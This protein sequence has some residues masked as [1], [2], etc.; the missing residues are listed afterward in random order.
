MAKPTNTTGDRDYGRRTYASKKKYEEQRQLASDAHI[1]RISA[2]KRKHSEYKKPYI[3]DLDYPEMEMYNPPPPWWPPGIPPIPPVEGPPID[4]GG[5]IPP[6]KPPP[7]KNL[8]PFLGC[9]F[10]SRRIRPKTLQPGEIAY[11]GVDIGNQDSIQAIHIYGPG[12]LGTDIAG[13]NEATKVKFSGYNE[14]QTNKGFC[15]ISVKAKDDPTDFNHVTPYFT[16]GKDAPGPYPI[17][18]EVIMASGAVCVEMLE[19]ETCPADIALE[20]DTTISPATIGRASRVTIAVNGGAPPFNWSVSG[21]DFYLESPKTAGRTNVL[22]TGDVA[23]GTATITVTDSCGEVVTGQ[24]RCTSG[25]WVAN[26]DV[27]SCPGPWT[28]YQFMEGYWKFTREVGGCWMWYYI[29]GTF[30]FVPNCGDCTNYCT[31]PYG[32]DPRRPCDEMCISGVLEAWLPLIGSTLFKTGP[33]CY[34]STSYSPDQNAC[35]C[36]RWFSNQT[37]EC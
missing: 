8:P 1:D 4:P 11:G 35:A 16:I 28:S 19:V 20:W 7:N 10:F 9:M 14:Y 22:S 21:N 12:I 2:F 33:W 23:C 36:N 34:T 18:V 17:I 6:S 29:Q 37:W 15:G 26:H 13:C 5:P 27:C 3:D 31:V 25:A 24:V 32:C 30:S